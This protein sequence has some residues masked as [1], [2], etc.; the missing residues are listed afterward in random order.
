[1]HVLSISLASMA[2]GEYGSQPC[3]TRLCWNHLSEF[4]A[5]TKIQNQSENKCYNQIS[6]A[7][8]NLSCSLTAKAGGVGDCLIN[9]VGERLDNGVGALGIRNRR[10]AG[11]REHV[12]VGA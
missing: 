8:R 6:C 4:F 7:L 12:E 1:M 3:Q 9:Q 11:V 2:A 5:A 10:V